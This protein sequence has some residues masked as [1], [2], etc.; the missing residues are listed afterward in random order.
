MTIDLN[1]LKAYWGQELVKVPADL[2]RNASIPAGH[3]AFLT[4]TGLPARD[5]LLFP[6][7]KRPSEFTSWMYNNRP[8]LV[9]AEQH[10]QKLCVSL[11]DGAVVAIDA[12]GE[13]A[14]RPVNSDAIR[15]VAF[16]TIYDQSLPQLRHA[17]DEDAGAIVGHLRDQFAKI[18]PQAMSGEENW[19]PVVLEQ[20]GQ[21]LM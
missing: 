16:L 3:F 8:Y 10:D 1:G 2:L 4:E 15:L 11:D 21:G 18:D 5:N 6:I 17:S 19:W 12:R 7:F 13:L 20:V 14:E 9:I